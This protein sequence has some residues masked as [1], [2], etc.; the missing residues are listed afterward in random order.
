MS[1]R[2]DRDFLSDV[3]EAIQRVLACT[4]GMTYEGFLSDVKTQDAVIRN[5]EIIGEATKNL[6]TELR[7][8]YPEVPW[9]SMA[10]T[11]DRLIHDHFGINLDIVWEIATIELPK[12][13]SR[14]EE[15]LR[16][17]SGA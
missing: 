8:K 15:I 6:A 4:S 5:L 11:R 9:K 1:R 10:G 14:L 17:E 3:R 2:T 16:Q 12:V 7:A 13:I